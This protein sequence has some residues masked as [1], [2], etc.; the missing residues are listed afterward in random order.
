MVNGALVELPA[1]FPKKEIFTLY[2]DASTYAVRRIDQQNINTQG[3]TID[4]S[5]LQVTTNETLPASKVPPNTFIFTPPPGA[6]IQTCLATET[7][8]PAPSPRHG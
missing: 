4:T 5:T 3:A 7:C 2:I 1:G 6:K 8:S